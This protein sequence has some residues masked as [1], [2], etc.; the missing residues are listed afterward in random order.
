MAFFDNTLLLSNAQAITSTAASTTIYDVTGA[1]SGVT[2][3]LIWG[4]STVFGEDIG[5]GDGVRPTAYFTVGTAF[6]AGGAAT[7]TVTIEAAV[8]NGSNVPGTYFVIYSSEAIPVATL[9]AGRNWSVPIPP[10][11]P[12]EPL[13]RFYRFNYTI[14]TGPM[15]SGTLTAGIL[16]NP[17]AGAVSTLYPSNFRAV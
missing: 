8:D 2:P 1:G 4:T 12:G 9:T 16:L 14:A 5:T 17:P 11:A 3:S 7:M 10:L 15:L 13:P 6:T